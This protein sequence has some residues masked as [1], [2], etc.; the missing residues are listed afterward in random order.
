M[1]TIKNTPKKDVNASIIALQKKLVEIRKEQQVSQTELADI[2]FSSQQ[3]ISSFE[4]C[5]GSKVTLIWDIADALGYEI[6][7]KEK[8]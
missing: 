6:A 3:N 4:K 1:Q 8:K 5:V 7:L 2:I